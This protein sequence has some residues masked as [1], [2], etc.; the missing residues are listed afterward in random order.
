[1][2]TLVVIVVVGIAVLTLFSIGATPAPDPQ[3][4]PVPLVVP[5]AMPPLLVDL[6]ILVLKTDNAMNAVEINLR[7]RQLHHEAEG[8][9]QMRATVNQLFEAMRNEQQ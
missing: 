9:R 5:P 6:N 1:M 3:P 8:A 2:E 4:E 7:Q